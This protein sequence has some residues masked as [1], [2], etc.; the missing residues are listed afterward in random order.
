MKIFK[1]LLNSFSIVVLLV[2]CLLLGGQALAEV[3]ES[4]LSLTVAIHVSEYTRNCGLSLDEVD[5]DYPWYYFQVYTLLEEALL[6]DGTPFVEVSDADIEAGALLNVDG[7]PKYPILFS[8]AAECISD[9]EAVAL[10]EYVS[11]G[12]FI[13]VGASAWT[14]KE[15]GSY[16][17]TF[18]LSEEMG[19]QSVSVGNSNWLSIGVNG[20]RI[21]RVAD[22]RLVNYLPNDVFLQWPCGDAYDG[23][24]SSGA[25]QA[26]QTEVAGATPLVTIENTLSPFITVK[27]YGVGCFIYHA[28]L[29]VPGLSYLF[30]RNAIEWAF[31]ARE[32]PL[33]RTSAWPY[34]N[35]AAF[36]IRHD[37][38]TIPPAWL[39]LAEEE[40]GV[41]G[42]YFITT[43]VCD[44]A[45][46]PEG[47][48]YATEHGAVIGSHGKTHVA[49]D[50]L[51]YEE[52]FAD[53][54][55]SLVV[56]GEWSG[57]RPKTFV[58]PFVSALL[59]SSMQSIASNNVTASGEQSVGPF[60]HYALSMVDEKK[61][62]P[63][64]EMPITMWIN[65]SGRLLDA[66]DGLW[67][68][69]DI[70]NATDFVYDIGGLLNIY[71]HQGASWLGNSGNTSVL[72]Y[73]DYATAK[74]W[75]WKTTSED[76]AGWWD[77][78]SNVQV[79]HS[80]EVSGDNRTLEISVNASL[81]LQTAL[82]ITL[83]EPAPIMLE[84]DGASSTDFRQ[85]GCAVKINSG[86]A[87]E[88]IVRWD[89][90]NHLPVAAGD[91][92]I[93]LAGTPLSVSAPG[94]LA[95]DNDGDGDVLTAVLVSDVSHGLLA[96]NTDG[97][98]TYTP[99]A[100]YTGSEVFTYQ[101]YDGEDY[102]DAVSVSITVTAAT[103]TFGLNDG[104]YKWNIADGCICAMKYRNT[105][106]TGALVKLEV[107]VSDTTPQGHMKL[108]VYADDGGRPGELLLDAGEVQVVNGWVVKSGLNLGVTL[109]ADYW[110]AFNM[111]APNE[112]KFQTGQAEMTNY[113]ARLAYGEAFPEQF[114][115]VEV[116]YNN[117]I[118]VIRG[119]VAL[120]SNENH[121]PVAVGNS[122]S[123]FNITPFSVSAPGVLANDNDADGDVLTAVLVSDVSHGLLALNT[124]GSFTYTPEAGYTG[125]EVF[126]YQAYDGE[127]YS[128][129]VSV[130][131]TVTA[132]TA[133][134]GLNDGKYKWNIADGCICAMKYRNTAGTGA[135]V[136]LEVL[137]SDTTPQGHMKLGVYADDGGRPG[138]LLLDAG[139]VQV[140]N[141]WVVKSGLNLGVTLNAD[142][143]L[144]FNMEAPNEVKFQTG[145]AEM[146]NYWARLAYGEAFP[147]Q[148]EQV[149]VGYNNDI[150]VI[151]GT[152]E[153]G[154]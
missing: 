109:N 111:E 118:F 117:D 121:V 58:A 70:R 88:V 76:L 132:A 82:D 110:L 55:D 147:E 135:L 64:V 48:F 74:P 67:T 80:Y 151:R 106:G 102:S 30:F 41:N 42:Q 36:M 127:D 12:G 51:T 68:D 125:S 60:P 38:Q 97:S 24:A 4:E 119:T 148:F 103:A 87:Q 96:L 153:L 133:T 94:V 8:L 2:A 17:D 83:P 84:L 9:A 5:G 46:M 65:D 92:Y 45:T 18:A 120:E 63:F 143:W 56:L 113:W 93:S 142:Y 124:D 26:W 19:L 66:N 140:V 31:E 134:F 54:N 59:D 126:T 98:F 35:Q 129:A 16:R 101:A 32:L 25:H 123:T 95:N 50:A 71:D 91:A 137:V 7:V 75:L 145:Q 57:S 44:A 85:D 79:S 152:V 37:D 146:T 149:E 14:R 10:R 69:A 72:Y 154:G 21:K 39:V 100:G 114:E 6:S 28:E 81:S 139:E 52:A 138:E 116:G 29:V 107:L 105:A 131:I 115:Q 43:S 112:V 128:D 53:L 49:Y 130:S 141:G 27:N 40:R 104:K 47:I 11:S 33:V 22:H 62:Y 90:V 99:E 23:F 20:S 86:N 3:D 108:G 144:A 136:K 13:Y 89:K 150:F 77:T 61:H 78:R 1:I 122:Y 73:L 15:D 34:P